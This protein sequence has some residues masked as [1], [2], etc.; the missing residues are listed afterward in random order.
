MR[1]LAFAGLRRKA[2]RELDRIACLCPSQ[3]GG[4]I[5]GTQRVRQRERRVMLHRFLCGIAH[6]G[7]GVQVRF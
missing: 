4:R 6:A 2:L 5:Q 1:L 3:I 7:P